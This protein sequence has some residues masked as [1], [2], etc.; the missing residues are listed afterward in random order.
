[1]EPVDL[2]SDVIITPTILADNTRN[3]PAQLPSCTRA[4]KDE[5]YQTGQSLFDLLLFPFQF[6][7]FLWI[8]F[9]LLLLFPAA[10]ISFSGI[11]HG[12]SPFLTNSL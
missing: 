12:V 6:S 5:N 2:G 1:M 8:Q 10:F 7:F 4:R 9:G 3:Q 11:M